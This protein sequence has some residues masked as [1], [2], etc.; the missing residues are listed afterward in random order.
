M[1][2]QLREYAESRDIDRLEESWMETLGGGDLEPSHLEALLEVAESVL[3]DGGAAHSV[4]TLRRLG[5][6]LELLCACVSDDTPARITLRLFRMLLQLYPENRSYRNVY[7][8]S[9][10][11][12]Y[13]VAAPERAFYEA[14]GIPDSTDI[15]AS[16]ERLDSLLRYREGTYVFH[17]S[18][19]GVGKILGVDPFLRQVR[20]D[21]E[22]K[23]DH[24]I[25]IDAVD[26]ILEYLEPDSFRVLF[27]EGGS[28]LQRLR[29]EE[30]VGLLIKVIEAFGN[31][32]EA[33]AIKAH[34]VPRVIEAKDWTRWWNK[35]KSL[36]R[37]T[38]YFRVGD[39]SPHLVEK[40]NTAISYSDELIRDYG[41]AKW[42]DAR[43]IA[44]QAARRSG[45][46][47][48]EAWAKI[49]P[50]SWS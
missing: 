49:E 26:S 44:K 5:T 13:P 18:G 25:A 7:C 1:Y 12:V 38:G 4:G 43:K 41:R 28:E 21:L 29:D 34:L 6:M 35:T 39:R 15:R 33:K 45:G 47:L 40:L 22:E 27:Y 30:P 17:E 24:R 20:V 50:I 14:V 2:T 36:L 11:R 46:E 8:E 23:P 9:Y 48:K 10:E 19:W 32:L 31:P 42:S 16:L 3:E 37:D